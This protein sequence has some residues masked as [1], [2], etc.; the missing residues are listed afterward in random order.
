MPERCFIG[1]AATAAG[2]SAKTLRYYEAVG[3]LPPPDR[4]ESGYRVY[5]ADA[6]RRLGFIVKAKQLG[7]SL[8]EI[9]EILGIR[10]GGQAPCVHL[11]HLLLRKAQEV[12][13]RIAELTVLR[14][15]LRRLARRCRREIR[16]G[17]QAAI[18]PHVESLPPAP[19]CPRPASRS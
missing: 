9:R 2:L 5:S 19:R 15:E 4:T 6:V 18:C 14:Q 11:Q 3:L 10:D 8:R 17:G 13:R 1:R 12:D 16:E 7:L